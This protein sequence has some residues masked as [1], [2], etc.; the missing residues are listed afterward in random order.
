MSR[1]LLVDDDADILEALAG[2]LEDQHRIS[3]ARNGIEALEILKTHSFDTMILDLTMPLM[4]G[5]T[6]L[7]TMRKGGI[8]LPVV[9]ASGSA[10]I[11]EL[12]QRFG[13][14]HITKPYDIAALERKLACLRADPS[15]TKP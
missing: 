6:L 2:A 11:C 13:V 12:A 14:D 10:D 1:L 7:A 4:D 9:L 5:E 15:E 8:A 3:T